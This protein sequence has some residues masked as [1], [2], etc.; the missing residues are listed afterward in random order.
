M[1]PAAFA[2]RHPRL[3]RLGMEGAHEG[4]RR[5]GLLT[6]AQIAASAGIV[7]PTTPRPGPIRATLPDGTAVTITDNLPLSFEALAP[8]LDD[9][10]TPEDWLAMLD[11]RVFLWPDR[12]LAAGNLRARRRLGYASEWQCYD[13]ATLLT[14]V[15]DR[16][17]IAPINTGSTVRRPARR[18][19]ATFAPLGALD[20][21]AWRRARGRKAPD[22]VKEV[23]VRG[24]APDAGAALIAVESA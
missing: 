12:R 17:E 3:H 24:G 23:T 19:R 6:A 13:A 22:R 21:D 1:T 5:H 10:L 20:W 9:G 16:A 4:V 2:A 14:P 15:W 11:D 8:V 7:L 18:G